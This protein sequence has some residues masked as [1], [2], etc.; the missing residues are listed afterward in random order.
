MKALCTAAP[1]SPD[2][3]GLCTDI[4]FRPEL[5]ASTPALPTAGHP[6]GARGT[7]LKADRG[8]GATSLF[9]RAAD[10][11]IS[12]CKRHLCSTHPGQ[13]SVIMLRT[14]CQCPEIPH[15]FRRAVFSLVSTAAKFTSQAQLLY[16]VAQSSLC[17]LSSNNKQ[18]SQRSKER[19][20]LKWTFSEFAVRSQCPQK[21]CTD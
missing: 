13:I 5:A 11:W 17:N 3:D 9:L 15:T 18:Q 7:T 6:T 16:S 21:V 19:R 1:W 10:T 20:R 2:K 14:L 12:P 4:I 8:H